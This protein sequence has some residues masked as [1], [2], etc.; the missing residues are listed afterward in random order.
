[1]RKYTIEYGEDPDKPG[2]MKLK[3]VCDGFN[4]FELLGVLEFI[5]MEIL[6]QISGKIKP[7]IIERVAITETTSL[8][9][10]IESASTPNESPNE[11]D[12]SSGPT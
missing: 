4:A 10:Q 11:L 8:K 6:D 9:E 2:K 12:P 7:D 1:M 5:Q 3:R